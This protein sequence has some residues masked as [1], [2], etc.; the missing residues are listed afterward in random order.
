[1]GGSCASRSIPTSSGQPHRIR[2]LDEIL[3]YVLSHEDV[4]QATADEIAEYYIANHYDQM[5]AHSS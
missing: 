1:M 5:V 3:G 4:W 2:Y